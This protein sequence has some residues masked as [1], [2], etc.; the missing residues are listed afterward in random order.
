MSLKQVAAHFGVSINTA[1]TLPIPFTKIGRQ[2]RY[3]P[4]LV[5]QY[6]WKNVAS[7]KDALVWKAA[8]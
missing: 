1:K 5:K 4:T 6:E 7:P 8:S 2:R 3:H